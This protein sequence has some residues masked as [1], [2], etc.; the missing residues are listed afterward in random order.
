MENF[1][2]YDEEEEYSRVPDLAIRRK[3]EW[4]FAAR[5]KRILENEGSLL[6]KPLH[7][8]SKN[9]PIS[10]AFDRRKI[11]QQKRQQDNFKNQLEELYEY[12]NN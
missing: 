12:H 4:K 1:Y 3:N 7:F 9:M 5:R 11:M 10:N 6:V 8:Y 2:E